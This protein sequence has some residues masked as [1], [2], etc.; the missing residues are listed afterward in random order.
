MYRKENQSKLLVVHSNGGQ[1]NFLGLLHCDDRR[2]PCEASYDGP[3][4]DRIRS[5]TI[6]LCTIFSYAG[7]V[8]FFIIPF[9]SCFVFQH[10]IICNVREL[11]VFE[12]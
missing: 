6:K 5:D 12:F 9:L 2:S 11:A 4:H 1:C 7:L 3:Q 8:I 10:E